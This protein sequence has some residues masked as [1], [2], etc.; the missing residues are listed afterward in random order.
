MSFTFVPSEFRADYPEFSDP[1]TFSDPVLNRWATVASNLLDCNRWGDLIGFGTGLFIA[2]QLAMRQM[3]LK[4][5]AAGGNPGQI[6]GPVA[7][8]SVKGVSV[9]YDPSAITIKDGGNFNATSYGRDFL[10]YGAQ[11]GAGPIVIG[12]GGGLPQPI[13]PGTDIFFGAYLGTSY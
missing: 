2:H 10:R 12:A 5:A 9:S 11:L 8:K 3:N 6:N 13:Y 4:A 1:Q 7:S